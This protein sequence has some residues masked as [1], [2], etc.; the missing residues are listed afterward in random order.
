M[1]KATNHKQF[2]VMINDQVADR[3]DQFCTNVGISESAAVEIAIN[4]F[5]DDPKVISG[6]MNGYREMATLN[7]EISHDFSCC[8]EDADVH[9][10]QYRRR[11]LNFY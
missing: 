6:L 8:E 7:R 10:A 3:L 11:L 4:Y 5:F 2:S 9:L 1:E